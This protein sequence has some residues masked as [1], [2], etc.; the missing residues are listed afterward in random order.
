[1]TERSRTTGGAQGGRLLLAAGVF[2]LV[3]NYLPGSGHLDLAVL[4][5]VGLVAVALGLACLRVPWERLHVRAPLAMA[6]VAF[7]LISL[8][9]LYGGVS[10]FSYAVYFVVVFVWVGIA[11]PPGRRGGCCRPP[12]APTCCRSC[13]ATPRRRTHHLI[14]HVALRLALLVDEVL[15]RHRLPLE[16][17]STP[18][19]PPARRVG[20]LA[21]DRDRPRPTSPSNLVRSA[22]ATGPLRA[23]RGRGRVVAD[24]RSG[25]RAGAASSVAPRPPAPALPDSALALPTPTTRS[26]AGAGGASASATLR[27]PLC[28]LLPRV[29]TAGALPAHR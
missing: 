12:P 9:N 27:R 18:A 20:A 21:A 8:S 5:T 14:R 15:A 7:A 23:V 2:T 28:R 29:R 24:R 6:P 3:N 26:R 16:Q 17:A 25:G 4:N 19:T 10:A 13:S 22:C 11:Q 1:V